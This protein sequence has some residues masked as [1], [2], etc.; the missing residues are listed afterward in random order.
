MELRWELMLESVNPLLKGTLITLELTAG[1]VGI[2]IVIGLFMALMRLSNSRIL[3]G[4]SI[5]YI[6]FFRGTPLL[7]Q[8]LMVYFALPQLLNFQ[9]PDNYQFIAA[10]T[11]M[12]LNSG[13]YIAEIFRAGI[14]S[15]DKGQGEAARSLG[16]TQGQAMRHVILPQAFKRVIPPL[17]NEFIALLKDSSLVSFIA[18]Q[19]LMYS[20]KLIVS[21]TY[22]PFVI[23]LEVAL[24][25]LAMTL[26]LSRFVNYTERRF[27][28][29]DNR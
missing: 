10:I 28:K 2:G 24:F 6:D 25:Y 23:Y 14:Q 13:A 8:L 27:G 18:L 4:L 21:R 1:A 16:M 22:Q 12:G 9:V 26:L 3:R 7:V 19:D 5:A 20:G 15:I 17:G 29:S 11:A